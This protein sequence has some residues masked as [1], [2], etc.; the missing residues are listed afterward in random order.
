MSAV[1]K[2]SGCFTARRSM[3]A[4]MSGSNCPERR[5]QV[6][7]SVPWPKGHVGAGEAANPGEGKGEG[8]TE[9]R[10]T[11]DVD[12]G[13]VASVA[14]VGAVPSD[15]DRPEHDTARSRRLARGRVRRTA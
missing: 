5:E 12:T 4:L 1:S 3:A 7:S 13:D 2:Y 14:V 8:S 10:E 9:V 11:R 15:E 6:V